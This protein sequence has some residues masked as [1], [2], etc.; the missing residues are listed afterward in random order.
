MTRRYGEEGRNNRNHPSRSPEE[1]REQGQDF[2]D[3]ANELWSLYG[4]QTE[5]H[6]K[7]RIKTLKDDMDG[8]LIFVCACFFWSTW[9][10]VTPTLG[11][12]ILRCSHRVRRAKDSGFESKPRRPVSLLPESIRSNAGSNITTT[13][14]GRQPDLNE[15]YSPIALPDL[16]CIGI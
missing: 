3:S 11:W 15:S 9:V 4:K 5:S 6:D 7:A 1:S 14:L 2:D 10:D 13:C 16:P 8:V 12:F